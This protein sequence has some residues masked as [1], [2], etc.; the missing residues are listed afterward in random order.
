ME[1]LPPSHSGEK[2]FPGHDR[3]WPSPSSSFLPGQGAELLVLPLFVLILLM[4]TEIFT[5][6][7]CFI[8][9]AHL[10]VLRINSDPGHGSETEP[11]P[12]LFFFLW[13]PELGIMLT[14]QRTPDE[15][16]CESQ[17]NPDPPGHLHKMQMP[18]PSVPSGSGS[19]G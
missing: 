15:E 1:K 4:M 18:R 19:P 8:D 13:F 5:S 3:S 14:T 11:S 2:L 7:H 16:L 10:L 12:G 9:R 17:K 6:P